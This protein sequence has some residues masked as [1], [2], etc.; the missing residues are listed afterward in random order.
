[1]QSRRILPDTITI[2]FTL[3]SEPSILKHLCK[4][5]VGNK[6]KYILQTHTLNY[7]QASATAVI[8]YL[9]STC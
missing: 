8:Y 5:T 9:R 1:M 4:V 6:Q 3:V 7:T 2:G